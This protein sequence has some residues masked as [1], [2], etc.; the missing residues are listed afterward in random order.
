MI[1]L[2][3]LYIHQWKRSTQDWS[4]LIHRS[5]KESETSAILIL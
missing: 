4:G 2:L 1:K 3:N 5:E